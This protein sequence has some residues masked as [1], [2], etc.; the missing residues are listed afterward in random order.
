MPRMLGFI[1]KAQ[2]IVQRSTSVGQ[3][4][5]LICHSHPTAA[6]TGWWLKRW[7]EA[8][9]IM[10]SHGDIFDRPPNSYDRYLTWF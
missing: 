10:I 7:R 6:I 2:R 1:L 8:M 4:F 5:I 9:I 3:P